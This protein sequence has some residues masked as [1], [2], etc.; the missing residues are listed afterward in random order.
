MR[1]EAT[2]TMAVAPGIMAARTVIIVAARP[3]A[4]VSAAVVGNRKPNDQPLFG[5]AFL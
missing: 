1:L 3:S 5:A 2:D 4:S